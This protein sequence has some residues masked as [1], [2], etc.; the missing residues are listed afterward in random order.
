MNARDWL[1]ADLD[2]RV[3]LCRE[4]TPGPW[5]ADDAELYAGAVGAEW[6]GET[7]SVEPGSRSVENAAA[8]I[9]ASDPST[10]AGLYGWLRGEVERHAY[11]AEHDTPEY[12]VGHTTPG[13]WSSCPACRDLR[14][15]STARG[16]C[17]FVSGLA[18]ALGYR[19]AGGG[20]EGT[21]RRPSRR[22]AAR[23]ANAFQAGR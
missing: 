1:L 4:T 11:E 22:S 14:S 23:S 15:F 6:I 21:Q 12:V 13:A 18:A 8:H 9:A 5:L 3:G 20:P 16:C 17:P 10:L 2:R 19:E 7:L